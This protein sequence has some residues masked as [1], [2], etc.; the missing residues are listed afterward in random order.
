MK[1]NKRPRLQDIVIFVG[2]LVNVVVIGIIL[3]YFV[4]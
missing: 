3:Y 4:L 1:P 2:L